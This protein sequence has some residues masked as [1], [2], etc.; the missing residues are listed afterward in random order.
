M[1][2]YTVVEGGIIYRGK[3]VTIKADSGEEYKLPYNEFLK[4]Y[5]NAQELLEEYNK[6]KETPDS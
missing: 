6:S 2:E 5:S 3:T 1:S 4:R